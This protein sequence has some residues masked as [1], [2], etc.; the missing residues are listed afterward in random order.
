MRQ[1]KM[2]LDVLALHTRR[3]DVSRLTWSWGEGCRDEYLQ[4]LH[5]L[6]P[7][8]KS[9]II[10]KWTVFLKHF[11]VCPWPL[12]VITSVHSPT[13]DVWHKGAARIHEAGV[14]HLN[15]NLLSK[16]Q[17]C[18]LQINW[19]F[20]WMIYCFFHLITSLHRFHLLMYPHSFFVVVVSHR[21]KEWVHVF[22]CFALLFIL[23]RLKRQADNVGKT[24]NVKKSP[25][26]LVISSHVT[27]KQGV[28]DIIKPPTLFL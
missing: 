18:P 25:D 20:E 5:P 24:K 1:F 4:S 11:F 17:H 19:H 10:G 21:W 7:W 12:R 9:V 14:W 6:S 16:E 26:T 8:L 3:P 2:P 23:F 28:L 27:W 13:H 22:L 15:K